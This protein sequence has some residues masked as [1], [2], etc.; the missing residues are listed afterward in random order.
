MAFNGPGRIFERRSGFT[1]ELCNYFGIS[2]RMR[3]YRTRRYCVPTLRDYLVPKN[4]PQSFLKRCSVWRPSP[5][6]YS[7]VSQLF[8]GILFEFLRTQQPWLSGVATC[9]PRAARGE[10][11]CDPR[12]DVRL[13]SSSRTCRMGNGSAEQRGSGGAGGTMK[14]VWLTLSIARPD[15][16]R[17]GKADMH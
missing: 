14:V 6:S 16:L 10:V 1:G 15:I 4:G 11:L 8:D 5:N 13:L 3:T 9:R 17:R 2:L 12:H 7:R